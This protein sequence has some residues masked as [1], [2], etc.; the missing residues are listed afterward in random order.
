MLNNTELRN[1]W[2]STKTQRTMSM[3]LQAWE[4]LGE[5]AHVSATSRSEAL[6]ILIRSASLRGTDLPKE[7]ALL[8]D[9]K[10]AGE[11]LVTNLS[12]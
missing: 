12:R 4:L 11:V 8:T 1:I 10:R 6:E 5:L 3:T 9:S 7:R 2:G